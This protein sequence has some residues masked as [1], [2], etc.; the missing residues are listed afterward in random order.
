MRPP[1]AWTVVR[2]GHTS[3]GMENAPAP[4]SGR[5]LECD[6]LS[7]EGVEANFNGMM[8]RLIAD[9]GPAAGKT[10][11]ATHVDSWENGSQNWTGRMREE[12]HAR[13]GYELLPWLPV[14]TGRVVGSL[15]VSERFLWDFR[16]TISEL[17]VE[18]YAGHLRDLAHRHGL[19]FTIE[20][21]GSPCD[22]LPYAG[23]CDE[24]MG[25]FWI[26]EGA[27][28]TCKGM[29]SA[30]HIYGRPIVG[31]ES[32]TADDQERWREHPATIKALGDRAFC[33]GINR[34]VFHR[35]AMQPWLDRR[36]G[37]TM[38]PWGTHYERTETWWE[39]TPAWHQY[40]ARCQFLLRQGRYVA[41]LCY[42]EAEDSPQGFHD[43][44]RQGYAWDQ[45]NPEVVLSR[46]QVGDGRL[47]L[48]DGMS[49]RL[50]V[51]PPGETMTPALLGKIKELV[52]AGATVVGPRP[53]KSPSLSG[54]PQCD[55][56]V[57]QL[58][59]ELWGD[60]DGKTITEHRCGKG[61][62]VWGKTPEAVLAEMGVPPDFRPNLP[63]DALGLRY[64]HRAVDGTDVYFVANGHPQAL[65]VQC[66]FRVKGKRPEFW[67]PDTGRIEPVAVYDEIG[68]G[69]RIPIWFDPSGS[70]FVVFRPD[71]S[72]APDRV[73]ALSR[74]GKSM[75][76][77]SAPAEIVV[78]KAMYGV[79]GDPARTRDVTAQVQQLVNQG[80]YAF[81]VASLAQGGDPAF[82]VVK[83]LTVEYAAGGNLHSS[84]ATDP[85]F[86]LLFDGS[87]PRDAE[88]RYDAD[89]RLLVEAW[90]PGRYE[91]KMASGKMRRVEVP[92][93]PSPL[94]V[95]GPWDLRFPPGRGAPEHVTLDKLISWTAHPDAGV[96]YFSGAATYTK[97]FQ[98]PS[99]M[100]GKDRRVYLDLGRV[101]AIAE[102]K[103]N[104]KNLGV[105]WKPPFRMDVTDA[106]KA[107]DNALEVQVVNL[108]PN[109]LIGDQQLPEDSDRN[110][111]GTLRAWPKWL[112]EGKPSPA[113]RYTFTTWRLW[114]KSDPLL[115]SGLLGPV[116]LLATESIPCPF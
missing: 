36:P 45:C 88:V 28:E 1:G 94:D 20:A 47:L 71:A 67:R 114:K 4:A 96:K 18:N 35:Y 78:K 19:R 63:S 93:L 30:A 14:L 105:L 24:P 116:R 25:E 81:Q 44:P 11:A 98:A 58:A 69:T 103:L 42:L 12:F 16:R 75:M 74:D 72:P 97:T 99:A 85:E 109:R 79:P 65:D 52:E 104:G 102:V 43:H 82:G 107:G 15:E 48:P 110:P 33:E 101:Q 106:V 39:L 59:A 32:F 86:I 60:C 91:V 89:G 10:L 84:S 64:I 26:G 40:L 92:A 37:M 66:T 49:Y 8:A 108:W 68:D 50:L 31:A 87:Q 70:L 100:I 54:Y 73:V 111:D 5:G 21:Y 17:V 90:K 113:G 56:Q 55:A 46:M 77:A 27:I 51:L 76:G 112:L 57:R 9:V 83:T 62:I 6:K 41:D 61:K 3:T 80:K 7:K 23:Q 95:A 29:A 34:F 2:F 13:R 38:G 22:H 53:V 115:E